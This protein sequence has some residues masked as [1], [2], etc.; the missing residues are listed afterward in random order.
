VE[1]T[2]IYLVST[3]AEY[4]RRMDRLELVS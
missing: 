3:G 1:T 2:R 4:L